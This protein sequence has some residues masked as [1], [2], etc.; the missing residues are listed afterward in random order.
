M[1]AKINL[2][3]NTAGCERLAKDGLEGYWH[4]HVNT[5]LVAILKDGSWESPPGSMPPPADAKLIGV[6]DVDLPGHDEATTTAVEGLKAQLAIKRADAEKELTDF[7][8]RIN[9]LLAITFAPGGD[10]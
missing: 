9:E 2:Y 10:K 7:H 3:L 4:W 6:A 1:K 8:R 5:R